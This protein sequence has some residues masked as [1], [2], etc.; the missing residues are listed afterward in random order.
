MI[1]KLSCSAVS[2]VQFIAFCHIVYVMSKYSMPMPS[3]P[4]QKSKTRDLTMEFVDL[5]SYLH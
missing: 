3:I 1:M 5:S 4:Q 2:W